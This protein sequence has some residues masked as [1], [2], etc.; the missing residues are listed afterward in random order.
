M[1]TYYCIIILLTFY[2]CINKDNTKNTNEYQ[3]V[4]NQLDLSPYEKK[5]YM[6]LNCSFALDTIKNT[7]KQEFLIKYN[8]GEWGHQDN[9]NFVIKILFNAENRIFDY[10]CLKYINSKT[11]KK[12]NNF[13]FLS[14]S[15]SD[16]FIRYYVY[17]DNTKFDS[18]ENNEIKN[19]LSDS[20]P[21]YKNRYISSTRESSFD[22]VHYKFIEKQ[23]MYKKYNLQIDN[24]IDGIIIN[25]FLSNL[26]L[27][28]A[29]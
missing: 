18:I 29:N 1:K 4:S 17:Y 6:Y 23:L 2:S 21:N 3:V 10:H 9:C 24:S 20:L 27:T 13:P 22:V 14:K 8:S 19:F 5:F 28:I 11:E 16:G 25:K 26:K 15:H 7:D 12:F